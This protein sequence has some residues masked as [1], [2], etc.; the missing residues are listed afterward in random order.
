M[1]KTIY[2]LSMLFIAACTA[3]NLGIE[4]SADNDMKFYAS[5][6]GAELTKT[7]LNDEGYICWTADDRISIFACNTYNQQFRFD[8]ETGERANSFTVVSSLGTGAVLQANYA[9]YPYAE[10]NTISADGVFS[11]T[12]PDTQAYVENS[13]GLNA[14]TMVAVTENAEDK[15]LQFKNACGFLRLSLYGD[16]TIK[17]ITLKGNNGEKISGTAHV[18]ASFEGVPSVTL[19]DDA[20]G[21]ITIDCGEGVTLGATRDAATVFYFVLPPVEFSEGITI[22]A[23]ATDGRVFERTTSQSIAVE[24]NT[25]SKMSPLECD[26]FRGLTFLAEEETEITLNN[27]YDPQAITLEYR[28][29]RTWM[30][31]SIGSAIVLAAG[32]SVSFRAGAGGN[33][34]GIGNCKFSMTG[35]TRASGN[36]MSLIDRSLKS[37]SVPSNCFNGLFYDCVNLT[38]APELPAVNLADHCYTFMFYNC[39]SLVD[40][41]ELPATTLYE[42]CYN[43]MFAGC[44][45]LNKAPELKAPV[46]A[47]G[48]YFQM[49]LDCESLSYVRMLATDISAM[50]CLYGWLN[51]VA[52][53]G[54]VEINR[55]LLESASDDTVK[56]ALGIPNTWDVSRYHGAPIQQ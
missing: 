53:Y 6:E 55:E 52:E 54:R 27:G 18:E 13:F 4:E 26:I 7:Y 32:D 50:D 17:K 51:Y 34:S 20:T 44:S 14:N 40:A 21:S 22:T 33:M 41:P 29:G 8:G 12:L 46:L 10:G 25:I 11:V 43:A 49:F 9:V 2:L 36:I 23:T 39:T 24:R 15:H 16:D 56:E 37:N 47:K 48:C 38:S 28:T 42:Y 35:K 5:F 30:P 3:D 19:G 1:K 31:Y 45:S